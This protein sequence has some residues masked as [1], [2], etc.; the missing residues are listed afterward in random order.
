M[1]V[2]KW[3][4][5]VDGFGIPLI[6]EGQGGCEVEDQ[7]ELRAQSD[8]EQTESPGE[9]IAEEKTWPMRMCRRVGGAYQGQGVSSELD[10]QRLGRA[11]VPSV[12]RAF[13]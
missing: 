7:P 13:P 2:E 10:I 6:E 9:V 8:Q 1:A 4:I 3:E 11:F 5:K 12:F